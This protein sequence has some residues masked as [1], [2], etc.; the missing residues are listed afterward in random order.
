MLLGG[1]YRNCLFSGQNFKLNFFLHFT[2]CYQASVAFCW[3]SG[4]SNLY[5]MYTSLITSVG[6]PSGPGALPLFISLKI[7]SF[8]FF[9]QG[10]S[11]FPRVEEEFLMSL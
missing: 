6:M 5:T 11:F 7:L 2:S 3:D 10:V 1:M 8:S 9:P 4:N